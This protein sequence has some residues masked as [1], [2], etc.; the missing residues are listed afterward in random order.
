MKVFKFGGASVKDAAGIRNVA[1]IIQQYGEKNL[2]V[3]VSAT[4]KTTNA[5]EDV[6]KA[7]FS[8]S[9]DDAMAAF[10]IVKNN[11]HTICTEL[12]GSGTHPVFDK[13]QNIYAE[14]D[15]QLEEDRKE[16]YNY[17]YDQIVSQGELISSVILSA[18]LNESGVQNTWLDVRD[19]MKTDDT[20]REAVVDWSKTQSLMDSI[21]KP[22]V[23]DSIIVTQGFIGCTPE[24]CTT[25]LGREGSDYTA[26]IFANML[27]AEHQTI[28]KDVPGVMNGDPRVFSDAVFIDEISFNEAVEMTFYG[29]TV[30]HPKT[31]KPLQNK[32][33]PLLVRSFI[34]PEGKGTK[35]GGEDH[36]LPPIRIVKNSQALITLHTKDFSFV[37]DEVVA[38]IFTSFSNANLKLNMMQQ[39]AISFE[40]VVDNIPEKIEKVKNALQDKFDFS[41]VE[42]LTILT[43]RHYSNFDYINQ[44]KSDRKAL[45]EQRR[46]STYQG[47]LV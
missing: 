38:E 45:L 26:A 12:F 37:E 13:L 9:T 25:T 44:F 27:D 33:I 30:I 5:L 43:I 28:W 47:L 32:N 19:V 29:A 34:N 41:I 16:A 35:V 22:V 36:N 39:G 14:V 18:Y 3:V 11:H 2:V 46:P 40:A 6:V 31:I 7:Y 4:G 20:Y 15:W 24:N 42:N 10:A 23:K 8:G 17:V 21:V 1:S